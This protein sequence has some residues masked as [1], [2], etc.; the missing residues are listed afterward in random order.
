MMGRCQ[1]SG[2]FAFH[3]K[4]DKIWADIK[5]G[6]AWCEPFDIPAKVNSAF[7]NGF[8]KEVKKRHAE[9]L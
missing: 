2:I 1:K 8:V 4:D 3:S 9:C 5:A 7:L 6:P